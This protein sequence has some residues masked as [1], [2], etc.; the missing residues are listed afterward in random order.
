MTPAA[1]TYARAAEL[2]L[3]SDEPE[4]LAELR[5]LCALDRELAPSL[6]AWVQ[7]VV[8]MKPPPKVLL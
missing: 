2:A 7:R 1:L 8:D 4:A 5:R 3:R 6:P